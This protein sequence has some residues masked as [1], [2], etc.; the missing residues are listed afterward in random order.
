MEMPYAHVGILVHDLEAAIPQYE[1]LGYTFMEPLTVHVD[2]LHDEDGERREID[3]RI[4]FALQ[5][6][7]HLELLEATGDGI[8]GA[9]HAGGLHHLAVLTDDPIARR[10]ELVEKGFRFTAAQYRPDGSM[11]VGYIHPGDLDGVRIEL[12]D[13]P[14]HDTIGRWIAGDEGAKP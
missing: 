14:V 10:D 5:G 3:L 9:Q 8:Y 6:P 13:A 7:P 12:L 2:D 4:V 1:K 11:I